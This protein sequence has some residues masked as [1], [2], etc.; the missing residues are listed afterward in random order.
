MRMKGVKRLLPTPIWRVIRATGTA[1]LTPLR[2]SWVTGHFSSTLAGSL[3]RSRSGEPIP[4]YTYPAI[5][6]LSQRD[7]TG[8]SVLE[9]GGGQSTM[10]WARRA[11]HVLTIEE[12]EGWYRTLHSRVPEN[13][14]LYHIPVDAASRS[15][16][17]I[18]EVLDSNPERRFD[19]IVVDGHLRRE[20]ADLAF[21]YVAT[22]GAIL[23][24]DAEGYGYYEQIKDRECQ[25][26][27]FFG[28]SP[29][30]SMRRSTSLI[31]TNSCFL[32]DVKIPIAKIES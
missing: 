25:R 30:V 14:T 19:V 2:F 28:F 23:L 13:V 18:R 5:D 29:G 9:F 20:L 3:A 26:V 27:D 1:V 10:W 6:F 11:K 4:W 12:D 24:D 21:D 32:L 15:I 31:F 7:F 8:R 16:A 17:Q 22:G